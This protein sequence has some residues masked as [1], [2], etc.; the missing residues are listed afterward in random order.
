MSSSHPIDLLSDDDDEKKDGEKPAELT[1]VRRLLCP[2]NLFASFGTFGTFASVDV[3]R[4][5]SIMSIRA[6]LLRSVPEVVFR[7]V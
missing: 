7:R 5:R 3:C 1:Q 4:F 2:F 6:V